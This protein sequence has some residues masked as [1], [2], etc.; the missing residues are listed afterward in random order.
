MDGIM[1]LHEIL[2]DTKIRGENGLVLKLDFEKAYDKINWN[3]LKKCFEQRGFGKRW[4]D[5]IWAVMTSG[6]LNVKVNDSLGHYFM[7]GK[8]VRQG[9]PLSPLL[10]NMAADVL[11]KMINQAQGN[12]LITGLATDYVE[13]GVAVLQYADDTILCLKDEVEVAR[14][15]KLLL[16]LFEEMSGLKI[17]FDKS[18]VVM[19]IE[20][21][22]KNLLYAEMF[23]CATGK[24]PLKYLG[25]PVSGARL[26]VGDWRNL[27]E[28]M[29][30][31]LDGWKGNTLS[32]GGRAT[33]INF[34]LS[35]IPIYCMSMYL[36]PKTVIK[37]MDKIRKRFFWQGGGK[38]KKYYLVKWSKIC[39]PKKKGESG[40]KRSAEVK[41]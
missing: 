23:N 6:T 18:E 31:R 13:N 10:F 19:V 21:D 12:N 29:M 9:D 35:S 3:F 1:S 26:H 28:K 27:D 14:N 20:D 7:C 24:W 17:N 34:C 8:G 16:Y 5:W 15:T 25:V 36:I 33:L 4:C 11:A 22:Q 30:K 38:K 39:I 40:N 32:I 37:S 2:H 41:H